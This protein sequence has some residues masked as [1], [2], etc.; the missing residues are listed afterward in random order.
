[1]LARLRS[2]LPSALV[3]MS[4]VAMPAC[5]N[6]R[7]GPPTPPG[8]GEE[9]PALTEADHAFAADLEERTFRWFWDTTNPTNGLVPDRWPTPSFSSIAAV[10]F[11][12][13]AY[14]IGAE[15]GWITREQAAERTLTTLRF[16]YQ[17]PQG[18]GETGVAGYKGFFYH[19]LDMQTGLRFQQVELSTI[20]T[21]LL[22]GGALFCR[23]YFDGATETEEAIRAYA[24]SLYH[25]VEWTWIQPRAPYVSMGWHPETGFIQADW[26][27]YNEAMLLYV[28]A[29][30]SPTHAIGPEA[31]DAWTST[32]QWAAWYGYA[33]VNFAPLFGHQYSHVWI[34][35]RGIQDDYM[36][37]RGIDYFENARRATLS[38][39]AYAIVNPDGWTGYGADFWGLTASDGPLDTTIVVDG[40]QRRFFTY[41]AR[42]TAIGEIVDD[43]TIVPTAAGGSIPF[44]PEATLPMLR[45]MRERFGDH[46]YKQY[47]FLDAINLTYPPDA[48]V[49]HGSHTPVGWVDGDYLGIDQGPIVAMIENWRSGLVWNEMRESPYIRLGLERAGFTG[50]WLGP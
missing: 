18:P 36:R 45:G 17:L 5:S 20:D 42:G 22:L 34:D 33:H 32:Y 46:L 35:F 16:M 6:A 8:G 38:Q 1:M 50:G 24:D 48:R 12:L 41:R 7:T 19:F 30:G 47:G 27:G 29:F 14:P 39:R 23:E 11:G 25:R 49:A 43:G 44:S 28:L 15:R 4:L 37:G 13:T 26:R 40:R 9:L 3:A 31:W 2:L 10:G 21:T